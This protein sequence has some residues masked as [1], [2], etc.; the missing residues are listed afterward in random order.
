MVTKLR[1]DPGNCMMKA[2]VTVQ[3][4]SPGQKSNSE[5]DVYLET[6]CG[7]L[8]AFK[9]KYRTV[10]A[11]TY[12]AMMKDIIPHCICPIPLGVVKACEIEFGLGLRKDV[13]YEFV[14]E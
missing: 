7:N 5:V 14:R 1:I 2:T 3:R 8:D 4:K 10:N 13:K 9:E 6:I 12:P 11:R